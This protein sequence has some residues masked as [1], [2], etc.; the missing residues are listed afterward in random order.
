MYIYS[1]LQQYAKASLQERDQMLDGTW[2]I[3][4]QLVTKCRPRADRWRTRASVP[5]IVRP[6]RRE[7]P[8]A[9]S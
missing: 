8:G 9:E 7:M 2:Q 6:W 1:V 3:S 5:L 4:T